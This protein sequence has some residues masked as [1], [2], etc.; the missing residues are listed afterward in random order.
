MIS[1]LYSL[2][3]D[4]IDKIYF[5]FSAYDFDN[6]GSLSFDEL[7][8][9]L[10][11]V[12]KGL[13]KVSPS[14]TTFTSSGP[15]D[16]EKYTSLLFL[17]FQ[18]YRIKCEQFR[19][20]CC[21]HPVMGSWLK[22]VAE[23][24]GSEKPLNEDDYSVDFD[25]PTQSLPV[26]QA[27]RPLEVAQIL[28][29]NDFSAIKEI[30]NV[31]ESRYI[32]KKELAKKKG[33][34]N[35]D[36]Q[37]DVVAA[38]EEE[39]EDSLQSKALAAKAAR[40]A[41]DPNAPAWVPLVDLLRPEELPEVLRSDP[42][43]DVFESI[44]ITGVS[45][46]RD[47]LAEPSNHVTQS[48]PAL[49]H[50]CV[51]YGNM[52]ALPEVV[53]P[54][55]GEEGA[56]VPLSTKLL[57]IVASHL[58]FMS[59]EEEIGWV[60]KTFSHHMAAKISCFDVHYDKN[61]I[62]TAD[63]TGVNHRSQGGKILIWDLKDFSI[64]CTLTTFYGVKYLNISENGVYVVAVSTDLASTVTIYEITSGRVV[65]TRPLF[66]GSR[67]VN[68]IVTDVM[69]TG[70]S[71]MFVVASAVK[72]ISFF[73]EEGGS[74]MG[75]N[76]LSVYEERVG[77]YQNVGKPAIGVAISELCRFEN[78]DEV[79]AGTVSGQI[80]LWRGRTCAQLLTNHS[81]SINA[82]DFNK[83][84]KTLIS[85]S[86][87]GTINIFTLKNNV[88]VSTKGPKFVAPRLLEL[89]ATF[90]ILRHNLCSYSIRSLSLSVDSKR[91]LLCTSASEVLEIALF[92]R[93]PTADELAEEE[94]AAVAAAEAAEALA[95]A[96]AEALAAAIEAGEEP[97]VLNNEGEDVIPVPNT[98]GLLGDDLHAGSIVSAHYALNNSSGASDLVTTLC[99]V[100]LGGFASCGS[101]GT[102]RWWQ[103]V[104][105]N[106]E[107]GPT[108]YRTTKVVKMDGSCSSVDA[109]ST[110]LAVA[111]Y[112]DPNQDRLGSV[113][114]F[115]L[116]ETQFVISFHESKQKITTLKF[117]PEGNILVAASQDGALYVYQSVEGQ[118]SFKGICGSS[119]DS[120]FANKLDFSSDGLY[121]RCFYPLSNDFRIYDVV[122][123]TLFGKNI[124]SLTDIPPA[125]AVIET[126]PIIGDD[127]E[128]V[129]VPPTEIEIIPQGLPLELLR[130]LTWASHSCAMN[131]DTKGVNSFQFEFG[132]TDRFNHLL[133]TALKSGF[134]AVER[135]PSIQFKILSNLESQ[136][137]TRFRAHDN[138]AS[139]LFFIDE[140]TKLVTAGSIDG[141]IRVW[142]VTYDLDEF[143]PD[144][145]EVPGQSELIEEAVE[146]DNEEE[147]GPPKLAPVYDSGEDED[148]V[149]T[150]KMKRH[151]SREN[152][153][154]RKT[155]QLEDV[156]QREEAEKL[157]ILN[158]A[159]MEA[160]IAEAKELGEELS[161]EP[162]IDGDSLVTVPYVRNIDI[163]K[164]S[165]IKLW[166]ESL[167]LNLN[168]LSS[169]CAKALAVSSI[170]TLIPNDEIQLNWVYGCSTR[171]VRA[172]V[173]YSKEGN[174]IYP[175]GSLSVIYDKKN[176]IQQYVMAH[177]D[178][179]TCLDVHLETGL[180]VSAHKGN[181]IISATVWRTSDKSI[182]H[183][184]N[185][186]EVNGVSSV[187]FSL[188]G[189]LITLT[190]Q[191]EVHTVLL[192]SVVDGRLLA[193]HSTGFKK[194][195]AIAFS[196]VPVSGNI[197]FLIGGILNFNFFT[198]QTSY[199]TLIRKI[200]SYGA[201]VKKSNVLCIS[202][203]PLQISEGGEVSGNEF[204]LGMSD[205]T[206]G[207]IAR[208]EFKVSGFTPVMK[209]AITALYV[210]KLKDGSADEPPSFRVIVGGTNGQL[211]LLDNELQPT[212]E[213][214]LYL[215]SIGLI[216]LGRVRG[217]KSLCTD[218]QNR[219]I[220]YSTAGGEIGE[221]EVQNGNDVNSGPIVTAHFRDELHALC[222]HPLRQE[223]V[224]AGDDKT[225]RIWSLDQK[226]MFTFIELPDIAR[227]VTYSPNGH[228]ICAGLGG[229][230]PGGSF[231]NPRPLNGQVLV[232]SYLQ[233]VLR[234]VHKISDAKDEITCVLFTPDGSK[235]LTSSKDGNVYI[236][237]AL[238]N[239]LLINTLT[240]THKEGIRSIDISA[241]GQYIST[242]GLY[243]EFYVW[244]LATYSLVGLSN[245]I[246]RFETL[247]QVGLDWHVRQSPLGLSSIGVFPEYSDASDILTVS[248]SN[249]K[250]LLAV[251]DCFG[252]LK[253]FR[254][255]ATDLFAPY[256]K[257]FA[258][259][260]GGLSK[261]AF[262]V[263]DEFLL[264]IGK[265]DKILVQWSVIKSN[266]SSDVKSTA[267]TTST[268]MNDIIEVS[269]PEEDFATSFIMKGVDL[270]KEEYKSCK[271]GTKELKAQIQSIVGTGSNKE[272]SH[273]LPRALFFGQ[274]DLL[275]CYGKLPVLLDRNGSGTQRSFTT[276][277]TNS[278]E[279]T[280][281]LQQITHFAVSFCGKFGLLGHKEGKL[282]I[283][284]APSGEQVIEL[285]ANVLGGVVTVA[286]SS[287]GQTCAC[288]GGDYL[289]SLQ[290]FK[291]YNRK[292]TD[293][294]LLCSS[295]VTV[296]NM[297]LLTFIN[298]SSSF[299]LVTA[300]GE[301]H[302][303]FW[304]I[305]GKNVHSVCGDYDD[306]SIT[307]KPSFTSIASSTT[308][309]SVVV[310]GDNNGSLYFWVDGKISWRREN[311]HKTAVSALKSYDNGFVSGC[312]EIL[313]VSSHY[314]DVQ[315]TMSVSEL[316]SATGWSSSIYLS[317]KYQSDNVI[318]SI[319]C[320]SAC[321][322]ILVSFSSSPIVILSYDSR[323][324]QKITEGHSTANHI[325][326]ITSIPSIDAV[327]TFTDDGLLRLWDVSSK[328]IDC[329]ITP[330]STN[331]LLGV[332]QLH[333]TPT[334][335]T[336]LNESTLLVAIKDADTDGKSGSI[337]MINISV[338]KVFDNITN[339]SK[340]EFKIFAR[341]HNV[342]K[343][344]IRALKLSPSYKYLAAC[345]EDGCVY[346]FKLQGI[347]T[348]TGAFNN[349]PPEFSF[350]S[351]LSDD[352]DISEKWFVSIGYLLAH[353]SGTPVVGLDFSSDN[354]YARTFGENHANIN[355]KVEVNF[356]DFDIQPSSITTTATTEK[357]QRLQHAASK[358]QDVEVIE[359]IKQHSITNMKTFWSSIS[360][361]VAS[362]ISSI[363]YHP[364]YGTIQHIHYISVSPDSSDYICTSLSDGTVCL[365]R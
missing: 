345:S 251:G 65:F 3:M 76:G 123:T 110:S 83:I 268:E 9:L 91:A 54:V 90:D 38:V 293:G 149:D 16:A 116:P 173:H 291:T 344:V 354:K 224:T 61:I 294:I 185:C 113:H 194:P 292:W 298:Y 222:V 1:S 36:E 264:S 365:N 34:N 144:P 159:I 99:R 171:S 290:L 207:V 58:I 82:L 181:G 92:I 305:I 132:C 338:P 249:D 198:Y 361:P 128:E 205:G 332:L 352:D 309:V 23:F 325:L 183:L 93:P 262:T 115:S 122:G 278:S 235:L 104:G 150:L 108:G 266:V 301:A 213:W 162:S 265:S 86:D 267:N 233:G 212:S 334:A 211:K 327:V 333:H 129:I 314:G 26:K 69:F 190:C 321:Q 320:D 304:N 41:I 310:T 189:S 131:W 89:H 302:I 118:W 85:G 55:D 300:G 335:V 75:A 44:W 114:L 111:L 318:T 306:I 263:Q 206:L 347:N 180:A 133:V 152:V 101:D 260:P 276:S 341:I 217:F 175:A 362:E 177:F 282:S 79:I 200:G 196:Q 37:G 179:I 255:P 22:T 109:S 53:E 356:F 66:L 252:T 237:D 277:S 358:V 210:M 225:L 182:L 359:F 148:L 12:V 20:Y 245:A 62:V 230:V 256:K 257:F 117:S 329:S 297:N 106:E 157:K 31:E 191:D 307:E 223:C 238:N 134:V 135:V 312:S 270:R 138:Y 296:G 33:T 353:P 49:I 81:T 273:S 63:N 231:R 336:V 25:L 219:K 169:N 156:A 70:T 215:P 105:G 68:D 43:E 42:P 67:V 234:I 241:S 7:T 275:T 315:Y 323:T 56:V 170:S 97:P 45:T 308:V 147:S 326:G 165:G 337:L 330:K 311:V 303:K 271:E 232:I 355:G 163:D 164:Y 204:L 8:L 259:S 286:F 50:R 107:T 137:F 48:L 343:G 100:P 146:E 228:L 32:A 6:A 360:S 279:Q 299:D 153:E 285:S 143:E 136:Q 130:G 203:M 119:T 243:D 272:S 139:S 140:G 78:A 253:L 281:L 350:E 244:D 193:S 348:T 141:T 74:F 214:N 248:Q 246:E 280:S 229:I 202:S 221:I 349:L 322:R 242:T 287:D 96:R 328:T 319:D 73:I 29:E 254:N 274:G 186:G 98:K 14:S 94:A 112:G 155:M 27:Y 339:I 167:G 64:K 13:S 316:L 192:F 331:T 120:T 103:G 126:T 46:E 28:S 15:L 51:R 84:T 30:E 178:E 39:D 77:L 289:H 199:N 52:D 47:V 364:I 17:H 18:C 342:G 59:K 88:V 80:L 313:M 19:Q 161:V 261:V 174:I 216:H 124:I 220:L 363:S 158:A 258:H 125:P 24:E 357:V 4:T 11:S 236:Y 351:K 346:M 226:K 227:S 239:F 324:V 172:A 187:K 188:D 240:G 195:L 208:G 87:D 145:V 151:L 168:N 57:A 60:Q 121:V 284:S 95:L 40:E 269:V 295:Q 154:K 5:A 209:G 72:G 184:L 201:D 197:R 35:D 160:A 250:T 127:G 247:G 10:R 71:S 340:Y 2:G 317:N 288:I 21:N 102:V 142:K 218:K 283:I 176:H 166:T